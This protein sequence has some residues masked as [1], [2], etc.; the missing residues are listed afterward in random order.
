LIGWLAGGRPEGDPAEAPLPRKW[1]AE[2]AIGAPD[3]IYQIP[4]PIEVKAEG[5]MP[6]QI[7]EV[8]T[9]LTTDRWVKAWEVQPTAREVVHHV[10][11]FVRE[12]TPPGKRA[13]RGD[14]D[15]DGFF[16]AFV[17]GNNHETYRDGLGKR[18]PAG[19][20]VRFQI[21]YTP[22]GHAT[23]DQVRVGFRFSEEPPRHAV[24]VSAVA[25]IGLKIPAGAA[26]HPE[27]ASVPVPVEIKVLSLMPHMHLRGQAFRF[28]LVLPS[29]EIRT[30]VEVPRYDFNWQLGY[31]FA[32]PL[33]IPA[34]SRVR[35]TGWFDNSPANPANPDPGREVRWGRQTYDE[36]MIG[37]VEYYIPS[38][39]AT[40]AAR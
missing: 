25:Q 2:W 14:D 26:G 4:S 21:H 19:S 1:P 12:P 10:L 32:E 39:P 3:A 11:V 40:T 16:A 22:N 13:R 31:R 20:V 9:G 6:Y 36:M 23:R 8:P 30:L 34:G 28:E 17:P 29:G 5:T 18:I 15:E 37:Y 35:A 38:R 33:T 24:E 27:T 7:V